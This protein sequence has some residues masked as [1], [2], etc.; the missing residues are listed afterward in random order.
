MMTKN[1]FEK[2]ESVYIPFLRTYG[3]IVSVK[4]KYYFISCWIYKIYI[5][6][7]EANNSLEIIEDVLEDDIVKINR[8]IF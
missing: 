8:F 6:T 4:S 1:Y 5:Y 2:D 3:N 7:I